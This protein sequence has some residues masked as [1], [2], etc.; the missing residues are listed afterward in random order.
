MSKAKFNYQKICQELLKD[1]S[2]RQKEMISRRFGLS[3]KTLKRETLES[4]GRSFGITRERVRQIE[5]DGISKIKP[6]LKRYQK[7]FQYFTQQLKASGDL[8]KEEILLSLLG[9]ENYQPQVF[10]LLTLGDSFKRY[11]ETENF[12]SL[13]TINPHSLILTQKVIDFFCNKLREIN[14][15]LSLEELFRSAK[16]SLTFQAL[17]SYLEISKIIQKGPQGVYGLKDWPEINPRGVKDKAYLVFKKEKKPLHFREVANLI[18]QSALPQTVHNELIKDSRFVLVG[19]GIYALKEWGYSEGQ[20]KDI[21]FKVLKE[22]KRPLSKEEIIAE[23]LKQRLVKENTILLNLSN[24]KYFLRD[25][26]KRY[27]LKITE[28]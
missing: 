22:A 23:V 13:W 14:Q 20:V 11:S 18:G 7:I 27:Q 3:P 17:Q 6:K 9:G 28:I 26:K 4:I 25:S 2:E 1:L 5:K 10:F 12:Y 21:I 16:F 15:P 19:R 24:K 8:R